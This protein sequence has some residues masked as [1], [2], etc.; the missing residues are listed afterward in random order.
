MA[1]SGK[2]N[3]T[4]RKKFTL[5]LSKPSIWCFLDVESRF[6]AGESHIANRCVSPLEVF[7]KYP[8][9]K[10]WEKSEKVPKNA[11]KSSK[12]VNRNNRKF[13]LEAACQKSFSK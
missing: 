3:N 10:Y 6:A 11:E 5:E 13:I 7:L 9:L 2:G 8:L 1:A 4:S 12:N